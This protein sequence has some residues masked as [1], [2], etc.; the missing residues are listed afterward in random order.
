MRLYLVAML[1]LLQA[2]FGAV[3][4]LE[5]PAITNESRG[6]MVDIS[7]EARQGT[8]D[9]Y[10][11]IMP[12]A[13]EQFQQSVQS[14]VAYVK[15]RGGLEDRDFLVKS[16]AASVASLLDG[17]S[18]GAAMAILMRSLVE[19]KLLRH[20]LTITG[21]IDEQGNVLEVGSLVEKADAASRAGKKAIFVPV[22]AP[23]S[24]AMLDRLA[25]EEP[26]KVLHYAN[27]D[28]AYSTFTSHSQEIHNSSIRYPSANYT[29]SSLNLSPVSPNSQFSP[30][31]ALMVAELSSGVS[32]IRDRY[33]AAY[34][35]LNEKAE[36]AE[37]LNRDG[38]TYSAGNEA[39]LALNKLHALNGSISEADLVAQKSDVARC[40]EATRES[41]DSYSGSVENYLNAEL[42]YFWAK[43][44]MDGMREPS[45]TADKIIL[46]SSISRARLWCM[47]AKDLSSQ[48]CLSCTGVNRTAIK[49]LNEKLIRQYF[50]VESSHFASAVEAYN[51]GYYGA[52][53]IE[54]LMHES[55]IN[56]SYDYALA[57]YTPK[58]AWARMMLAHADY[59]SASPEYGSGPQTS[60][61]RL[62]F[63]M[64]THLQELEG[65]GT[66]PAPATEANLTI[67][68]G[69]N[70]ACQPPSAY[71]GVGEFTLLILCCIL[72]VVAVL[73]FLRQ[74]RRKKGRFPAWKVKTK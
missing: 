4:H 40:L 35:Y 5:L 6:V 32:L 65:N 66:V 38:Y 24:S 52:A 3:V 67:I 23:D 15:S 61:R 39:F 57:N 43:R 22:S 30:S 31:V 58:S 26:I 45:T 64:D 49:Q 36:I 44:E 29:Y 1:L 34:R 13:G 50:M 7:V 27:I 63:F 41:L 19:G 68:V 9:V 47:I 51:T 55:E 20:D 42:R 53:L 59:L 60:I 62:A 17:P 73:I 71:A 69:D 33:P 70:D 16:D 54:L 8:G 37:S 12:F 18:A 21:G 28:E 48:P 25:K 46:I 11:S 10:V 56:G 74:C 72:V 14:S 2:V